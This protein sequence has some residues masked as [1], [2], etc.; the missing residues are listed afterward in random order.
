MNPNYPIIDAD[1]HVLEK[2]R[3]LH[4]YLGGRYSKEPRFETY[5]YFPSLDGWNRG[6][7][8]PGKDPETRA[9][10]WLQFLDE[11]GVHT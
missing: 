2:D 7:G 10:R 5:A 6:T 4:D 1:G 8:V 9:P 3:E 11:L